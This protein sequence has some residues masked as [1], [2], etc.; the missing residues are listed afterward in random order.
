MTTVDTVEPIAQLDVT[1][2]EQ[3]RAWIDPRSNLQPPLL[4]V[5][6]GLSSGLVPRANELATAICARQGEI[7]D[8]L[9]IA[10]GPAI[11]PECESDLYAWA[12]HCIDELTAKHSHSDKRT[13]VL[14]RLA[15]NM[16]G[17]KVPRASDNVG[18]W[19]ATL[20][21]IKG[22]LKAQA[23]GAALRWM[24]LDSEAGRKDVA[25][26]IATDRGLAS[27]VRDVLLQW[28]KDRSAGLASI[29]GM[30]KMAGTALEAVNQ[31]WPR[32]QADVEI[33]ATWLTGQR[34]NPTRE[35]MQFAPQAIVESTEPSDDVLTAELRTLT[36]S[37]QLLRARL[38]HF[39]LLTGQF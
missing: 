10:A 29:D 7:E 25:A 14:D 33:W 27:N 28:L 4:I 13:T 6:A 30:V 21:R 8:E 34:P 17:N 1:I 23:D 3:F 5:G 32:I 39:D 22:D 19:L 9:Q 38:E 16:L 2:D 31:D 37:G 26:K 35:T 36:K 15:L 18:E 20:G 24:R 12:G 11:A